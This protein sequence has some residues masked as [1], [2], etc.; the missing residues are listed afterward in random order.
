[1]T[2]Y[3]VLKIRVSGDCATT[4]IN[5]R[6]WEEENAIRCSHWL[7]LYEM[8][9]CSY[10]SSCKRLTSAALVAALI[11]LFLVSDVIQTHPNME[12]VTKYRKLE[13]L[14]LFSSPASLSSFASLL[15]N[16]QL[17][18]IT[19]TSLISNGHLSRN[20]NLVHIITMKS[21]NR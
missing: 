15:I 18:L 5:C 20:R 8:K 3:P 1:M 7:N 14:F 2:R 9:N 4:C 6:C 13:F 12:A 19:S 16:I 21:C 10:M 17:T 11:I